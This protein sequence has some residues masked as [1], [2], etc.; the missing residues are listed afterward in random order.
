MDAIVP[1]ISR[2]IHIGKCGLHARSNDCTK[3]NDTITGFIETVEGKL[4]GLIPINQASVTIISRPIGIIRPIRKSAAIME[5][6]TFGRLVNEETKQVEFWKS[7]LNE[8]HCLR[9]AE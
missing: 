4:Q 5:G 6:W 7:P 3:I 9:V 1:L 2:V 8:Q